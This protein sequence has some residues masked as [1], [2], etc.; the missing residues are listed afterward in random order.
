MKKF[1][2]TIEKFIKMLYNDMYLIGKN[3]GESEETIL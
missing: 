3:S 2:Y 1:L